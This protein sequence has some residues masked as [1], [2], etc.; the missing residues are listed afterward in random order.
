MTAISQSSSPR[1]I[2]RRIQ[3]HLDQHPGIGDFHQVLAADRRHAKSALLLRVDQAFGGKRRQRLAQRRETYAESF[4]Q[5]VESQRLARR[6]CAGNDLLAQ[7]MGD[8]G[9]NGLAEF[10]AGANGAFGHDFCHLNRWLNMP[11]QRPSCNNFRKR[12]DFRKYSWGGV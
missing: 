12:Y 2:A 8:V 1:S 9:G 11:R 5:D 6:K 4:A 7:P 3:F 10:L